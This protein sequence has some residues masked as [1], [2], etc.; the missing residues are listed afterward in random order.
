MPTRKK[1]P[2][3]I[4]RVKKDASEREVLARARKEFSAADLQKFTEIEE[5][6]PA[7]QVLS[8]MRAIHRDVTKK[9][10]ARKNSRS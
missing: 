3:P 7:R 6:V 4:M 9:A 5:G 8:E 2:L 1:S 10:K